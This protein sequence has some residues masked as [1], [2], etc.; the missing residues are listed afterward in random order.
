LLQAPE[1]RARPEPVRTTMALAMELGEEA[2]RCQ[3]PVGVVV[4]DAWSLAED[5]VRVLARRRQAWLRLLP[6]HRRLETA[7]WHRRAAHGGPLKLPGPHRAGEDLG[8]LLP[9]H[10]DRPVT[11][12]E[13]T[14]GCVTRAVRLRGLGQGRI[15][16]SWAQESLT[17]RAGVVVTNRV[18]WTAAQI[19]GLD[20]P[21]WPTATVS[22][23]SHGPLGC[24]AYRLR[25]VEAIGTPWCRV[26]VASSRVPRT[27]LPAG[28]ARTQGL[29]HTRG[30]AG[31][32]QGRARRQTLRLFVYAQR[33]QGATA[34]HVVAHFLAK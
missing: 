25:R 3:V 34:D 29:I 19:I 18:D 23:D 17:G 16:V 2:M 5:G 7:R 26:V 20:W 33:S 4:F 15:V 32:P 11:V 1:L 12:R 24:T 27:G 10:A 8:P 21:R 31:R 13:P 22:P 30:D 14:D 6:K 9:G 28:P